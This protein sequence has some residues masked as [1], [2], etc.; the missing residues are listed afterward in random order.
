MPL[1][2]CL[3]AFTFSR[4][5]FPAL[6]GV[7]LRVNFRFASPRLSA[8]GRRSVHGQL[9]KEAGEGVKVADGWRKER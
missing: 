4:A 5:R 2:S 6:F 8:S 3:R 7:N 1:P 9:W